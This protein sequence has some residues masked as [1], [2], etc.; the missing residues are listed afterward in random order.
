MPKSFSI[1]DYTK[2]A[3][4]GVLQEFFSIEKNAG[5][6]LWHADI[7]QSK[8][9]IADKYTINLE[10]VEKKPSI[11]V[12]RGAQSWGRRGIDQLQ[13]WEGPN[14]GSRHTDIVLGT[15]NCT[16]MSANGLEAESLADTVF[17][18]FSFF[19]KALREKVHALQDLQGVSLGEELVAV[20]DSKHDVSVVPVTVSTAFQWSW[21]VQRQGKPVK[22]VVVTTRD[23]HGATSDGKAFDKFLASAAPKFVA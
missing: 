10:D 15:F 5:E 16:C 8:I 23:S 3:I 6:F 19:R 20:T 2:D 22:D 11:V 21:L 7:K 14:T 12:I 1:T 4:L 18:F 17:A 13:G 9:L